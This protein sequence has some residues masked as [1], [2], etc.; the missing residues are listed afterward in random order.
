[1]IGDAVPREPSQAQPGAYDLGDPMRRRLPTNGWVWPNRTTPTS[2]YASPSPQPER[3]GALPPA[4]GIKPGQ[5]EGDEQ[6]NQWLR[7]RGDEANH[8]CRDAA[9][10]RSGTPEQSPIGE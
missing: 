8:G 1:M 5:R 3:G 10:H 9:R 7:T 6:R 2:R 4:Q